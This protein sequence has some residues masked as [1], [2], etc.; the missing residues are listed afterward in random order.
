MN[1]KKPKKKLAFLLATCIFSALCLTGCG[2]EGKLDEGDCKCNI[3]FSDIPKEF[4]MLEESLLER[5]EIEV[6]LQ[7]PI[8]EKEYDITLN[9]DNDFFAQ[10]SL[11]PGTYQVKY[12][13]NNMKNF[14]GISVSSDVESVE[15]SSAITSEI[16]ITL[17][18]AAE[19]SNH[20]MVTQPSPEI[21]LADKFSR[22]IQVDDKTG[23]NAYKIINIEDIVSEL[24][25]S[26]DT[27][28]KPYEKISLT[29]GDY[30]ITVFLLN[31]SDQMADWTSCEVIGI[32][33]SKNTVVFPEGVTLGMSTDKILHKTDGLYGAPDSFTGTALFGWGYDRVQAIYN[34]PASG[35][36]I[37]VTLNPESTYCLSIRYEFACFE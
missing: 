19:F 7:N 23:Q 12:V 28:V 5:F 30:G 18:N 26:Y 25:L 35:D 11:N 22:Q 32:E 3:M 24:T 10:V 36:K 8:T 13:S 20:W 29:D 31:N 14:N 27:Q 33:V 1:I 9:Q 4:Q 34:D 17:E 21:R 2:K 15:L 37:T 16:P 6:T